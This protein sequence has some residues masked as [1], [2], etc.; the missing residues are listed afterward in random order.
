MEGGGAGEMDGWREDGR[1]EGWEEG[2]IPSIS[3]STLTGDLHPRRR[4]SLHSRTPSS[5]A[6]LAHA[7]SE[8]HAPKPGHLAL[9]IAHLASLTFGITGPDLER[10]CKPHP[11]RWK[12][13]SKL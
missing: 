9:H 1:M 11:P 3:N 2:H 7:T 12:L 8:H 13:A 4:P 10:R 6:I 5:P